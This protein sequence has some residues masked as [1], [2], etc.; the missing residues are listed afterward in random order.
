MGKTQL[1]TGQ[2]FCHYEVEMRDGIQCESRPQKRNDLDL[3][4]AMLT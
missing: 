2:Y 4:P 3:M 1:S